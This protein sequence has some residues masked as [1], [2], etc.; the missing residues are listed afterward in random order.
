VI[1]TIEQN[2][3][4]DTFIDKHRRTGT[5]SENEKKSYQKE[6]FETYWL[7]LLHKYLFELSECRLVAPG[8]TAELHH[9]KS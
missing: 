6:S 9:P 7:Q 2:I 8:V 5:E 3:F 1:I 4:L